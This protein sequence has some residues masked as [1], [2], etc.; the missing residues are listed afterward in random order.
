[1]ILLNHNQIWMT[2]LTNIFCQ[3]I[4]KNVNPWLKENWKQKKDNTLRQHQLT[5]LE[6]RISDSL[7]ATCQDLKNVEEF[8]YG[9]YDFHF[10]NW[11]SYSV[12]LVLEVHYY[13]W[14]KKVDRTVSTKKEI[15]RLG[16][17]WDYSNQ[18]KLDT[19]YPTHEHPYETVI[20][21]IEEQIEI[22]EQIKKLRTKKLDLLRSIGHS[23][24]EDL[25]YEAH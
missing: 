19:C 22:D 8:G 10:T 1:M 2:L 20:K 4:G 6:K 16:P 5:Q 23:Y 11:N 3:N 15:I 18:E 17:D 13:K 7:E 25:D 12:C 24:F 14:P 21:G 9:G